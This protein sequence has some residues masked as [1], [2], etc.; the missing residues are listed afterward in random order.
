MEG[1][2]HNLE[3]LFDISSV[4]LEVVARTRNKFVE[5]VAVA[6]RCLIIIIKL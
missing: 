6:E 3:L 1:F 5:N 2:L 4:E